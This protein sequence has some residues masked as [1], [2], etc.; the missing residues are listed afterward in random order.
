MALAAWACFAVVTKLGDAETEIVVKLDDDL[1]HSEYWL[2]ISQFDIRVEG[3]YQLTYTMNSLLNPCSSRFYPFSA[4]VYF[5]II[6][7]D[8]VL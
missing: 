6:F 4:G 5:L 1:Y 8:C 7:E 3:S 2:K